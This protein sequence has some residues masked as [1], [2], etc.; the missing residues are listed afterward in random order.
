VRGRS[1]FGLIA[2]ESPFLCD[3]YI[4]DRRQFSGLVADPFQVRVTEQ[5]ESSVGEKNLF[6]LVSFPSARAKFRWV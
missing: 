3:H 2:V 1:V 6:V 4:I 5:V